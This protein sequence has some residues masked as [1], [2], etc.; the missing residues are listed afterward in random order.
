MSDNKPGDKIMNSK[1]FLPLFIILISFLTS[2]KKENSSLRG[3]WQEVK[4]HTYNQDNNT[5]AVSEEVT[6]PASMFTSL[7]YVQFN[8][9]SSC[10]ISQGSTSSAT[11]VQRIQKYTYASV[12]S[13][14]ALTEVFEGEMPISGIGIA[15]TVSVS[16]SNTLV[17]HSVATYLN[18]S[19]PYKSISDAYYSR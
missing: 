4:Y 2:C 1:F 7:D 10:I 8:S 5:G 9:S 18:P 16:S 17:I 3:K 6:Y 13:R 15:D 14:Y 11:L 12:G 19:V